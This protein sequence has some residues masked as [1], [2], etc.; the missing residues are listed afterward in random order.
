MT[1]AIKATRVIRED[2]GA[3]GKDGADGQDGAPGKDGADGQDGA[4]GKDGQD[5]KDGADGKSAYDLYVESLADPTTALSE[6][7]WLRTVAPRINEETGN[8]EVFDM[9]ANAWVDTEINARGTDMYVT[10]VADKSGWILWINEKMTDGTFEAREIFLP[11]VPAN[12]LTLVYQSM[13]ED[14]DM[15]EYIYSLYDKEE[16]NAMLIAGTGVINFKLFGNNIENNKENFKY[17]YDFYKTTKAVTPELEVVGK[18]VVTAQNGYYT[19]AVETSAKNFVVEEGETESV[20]YKASLNVS[21]SAEMSGTAASEYFN[22]RTKAIDKSEVHAI[23]EEKEDEFVKLSMVTEPIEF[24]YTESLNLPEVIY[25]GFTENGVETVLPFKE[26]KP[27]YE[28]VEETESAKFFSVSEEGVVTAENIDNDPTAVINYTC[29]MTVRYYF[30]NGEEKVYLTEEEP[31]VV[32]AVRAEE[33]LPEAVVMYD[34]EGNQNIVLSWSNTEKQ[35][36]EIAL[37]ETET[38][39]YGQVG[40]RDAFIANCTDVTT[41]RLYRYDEENDQYVVVPRVTLTWTEKPAGSMSEDNMTLTVTT[42]TP[43]YMPILNG[44]YYVTATPA[45]QSPLAE[46]PNF[47]AKCQVPVTINLTVDLDAQVV[48]DKYYVDA[49]GR[50][51]V[52]GVY[53]AA[54]FTH[55]MEG[56]LSQIFS[57]TPD[58]AIYFVLDPEKQAEDIAELIEKNAIEL[59]TNSEGDYLIKLAKD[60]TLGEGKDEVTVNP[61][62][63][64][65]VKVDIIPVGY[66]GEKVLENN[67]AEI[68]F[69]NPIDKESV[70]YNSKLVKEIKETADDA[71]FDL[72]KVVE[73]LSDVY[74]HKI[75]DKREYTDWAEESGYGLEVLDITMDDITYSTGVFRLD[76]QKLI[77]TRGDI[78]LQEDIVI[79]VTPKVQSNWGTFELKPLTLKV[80]KITED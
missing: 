67:V 10:E 3:P 27:E 49:N 16:D 58:M 64:S 75:I 32:K 55:R 18:P 15:P 9:D 51:I 13:A 11:A 46:M 41:Y 61:D 53:D 23:F 48:A 68:V 40:G 20:N 59:I 17:F 43:D 44:T 80:K 31:F 45:S 29:H 22:I 36:V 35:S 28:I 4:P 57:V 8:W 70:V 34:V 38:G 42:G 69:K 14:S 63:L 7:E 6:S 30:V 74:A 1:K 77:Y 50:A 39:L 2:Q 79:T 33:P 78:L 65:A 47:T 21:Y 71:S 73:T 25:P 12:G 62:N 76:G 60:A 52:R 54:T 56:N 66:D 24:V 19:V 5:G 26:V 72:T 37:H